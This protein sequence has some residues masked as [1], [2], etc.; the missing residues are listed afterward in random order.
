M[1][2]WCVCVCVCVTII[3]PFSFSSLLL[4]DTIRN[5]STRFQVGLGTYVD[6]LVEPYVGRAALL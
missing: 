2:L 1:I 5:I 6:K 3:F 4:A